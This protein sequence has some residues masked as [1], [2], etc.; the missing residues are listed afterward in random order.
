MA[1][2]SFH[3]AEIK[4]FAQSA[5][6]SQQSAV[7]SQQSAVSSQQSAVSK[8]QTAN[9][10]QQTANSKQQT[11]KLLLRMNQIFIDLFFYVSRLIFD[12]I[13]DRF[14]VDFARG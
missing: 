10:S 6:S 9:S 11:A 3:I 4:G 14:S 1:P 8:Q 2:I 5:V 7:S 13:S 12:E